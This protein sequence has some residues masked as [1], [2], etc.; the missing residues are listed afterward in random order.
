MAKLAGNIPTTLQDLMDK[1]EE[2]INA[3]ETIRALVESSREQVKV[4][5]KK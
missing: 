1:A 4:S 3:K 5:K 2:F